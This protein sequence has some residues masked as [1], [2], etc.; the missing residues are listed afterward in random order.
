MHVPIVTIAYYIVKVHIV[1]RML[2]AIQDAIDRA[3]TWVTR[4]KEQV[5][6]Q[7]PSY[8]CNIPGVS[9][10]Y[11]GKLQGEMCHLIPVTQQRS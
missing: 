4:F 11:L 3:G 1:G 9:E 8:A 7:F 5:E 10:L 2:S 6:E